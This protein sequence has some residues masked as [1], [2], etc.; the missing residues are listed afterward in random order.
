MKDADRKA[1]FM[2]CWAE[3][4]WRSEVNNDGRWQARLGLALKQ[5]YCGEL[6]SAV[7]LPTALPVSADWHV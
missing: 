7:Q 4:C 2:L 5:P 3:S 6:Y 1:N